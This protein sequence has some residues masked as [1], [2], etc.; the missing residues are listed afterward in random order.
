[1]QSPKLGSRHARIGL[2]TAAAAV[3]FLFAADLTYR[4]IMAALN[5]E[6]LANM[7]R[8]TLGRAEI[9]IDYALIKLGELYEANDLDCSADAVTALEMAVIRA[10]SIKDILVRDRHVICSAQP[11]SAILLRNQEDPQ[12]SAPARNAKVVL[13]PVQIAGRPALALTWH[14]SDDLQASALVN[15]EAMA[16]DILP[17]DF[18]DKS[19]VI[20]KLSNSA[21]IALFEG[22]KVRNDAEPI[23][24]EHAS[25]RF[26]I[27]A[28]I[29]V[30]P[31][32]ISNVHLERGRFVD[33][34]A[35]GLALVL[36]YLVARGLAP[37]PTTS[38]RIKSA[39]AQGEIVP[40]FQPSYDLRNGEMTGFE[41]L[42]RWTLPDGTPVSPSTFVPL[43]EANGWTNQ[44][45]ESMVT[46]AADSMSEII[47]HEPR[48]QFAFNISPNQIIQ[49]DFA[50][51]FLQI[52]DRTG[53]D[54]SR[55]ILEVTER[56]EIGNARSARHCVEALRAKGVRIA[57]DDAGT[58]HNGLAS[59]RTLGASVLKI[60]KF[61]VDG[62]EH[63]PRVAALVRMLVNAAR[64]YGMRIVAEGVEH[65]VQL[66]A[67]ARLGV[68]EVQG[69]FLCPPL[70][71]TQATAEFAR[72][73]AVMLRD[74][75]D[76]ADAP[77]E[78]TP[79]VAVESGASA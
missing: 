72:H 19:R 50:G 7:T 16:F 58:G 29:E 15:T 57:I 73:Q 25:S 17:A 69:F 60:D 77:A 27:S 42:A 70:D 32:V 10:G 68:D 37:P 64:E 23:V 75:L 55:V 78:G 46:Q 33:L 3:L 18:R 43:I 62:I 2:L 65:G 24:F 38:G 44:L 6:A 76:A 67:L 61:F 49:P 34:G 54:P 31:D 47:A 11:L 63:D 74:R 30:P 35:V 26:P 14:L 1:M 5:R 56:Q 40:H 79:Q 13:N 59:I 4:Q 53:L 36:A 9:A 12:M 28:R 22:A 71:A 21:P 45:L 48:L 66:D 39:L 41:V 51:W 8:D 52:V 20:L